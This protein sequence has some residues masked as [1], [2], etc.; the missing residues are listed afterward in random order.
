MSAISPPVVED[1]ESEGKEGVMSTAR[2]DFCCT[3]PMGVP[4]DTLLLVVPVRGCACATGMDFGFP[5]GESQL[6]LMS[7][8]LMTSMTGQATLVRLRRTLSSSGSSQPTLHSTC[9]SRNV[10]TVPVVEEEAESSPVL[11][12]CQPVWGAADAPRDLLQLPN[13][14]QP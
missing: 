10:R 14:S 6:Y 12:L 7:L 11:I 5:R 3:A 9:E 2:V 13:P 8:S 1:M 4:W